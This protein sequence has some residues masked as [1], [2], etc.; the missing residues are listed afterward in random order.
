MV[1]NILNNGIKMLIFLA[2]KGAKE[3]FK[4]RIFKRVQKVNLNFYVHF[5]F[6]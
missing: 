4:K 5:A 2:A 3:K 1:W 6:F